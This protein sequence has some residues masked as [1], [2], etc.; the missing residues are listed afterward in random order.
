MRAE[1]HRE[2]SFASATSV[3][4][5]EPKSVSIEVPVNDTVRRHLP[6]H[7]RERLEQRPA[8]RSAEDLAMETARRAASYAWHI[9]KVKERAA[10]ETMRGVEAAMR[11]EQHDAEERRRLEEKAEAMARRSEARRL[12]MWEKRE[13]DKARRAALARSVLNARLQADADKIETGQAKA[14]RARAAV[15]AREARVA[16]VAE[17]GGAHFKRARAVAEAVKVQKTE[18]G[19]AADERAPDVEPKQSP[20]PEVTAAIPRSCAFDLNLLNFEAR[21]GSASAVRRGGGGLRSGSQQQQLLN[22]EK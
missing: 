11:R 16:H 5:P 6:E 1:I 17:R 21:F 12:A 22:L 9:S 19:E 7:L 14:S 20:A 18:R 10:R 15:T 8:E 4:A 3:M 2:E 13:G